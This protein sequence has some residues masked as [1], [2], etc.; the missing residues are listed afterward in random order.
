MGD[1]RNKIKNHLNC[2]T[3]TKLIISSTFGDWTDLYYLYV[4]ETTIK[5]KI[6]FK[7]WLT[8]FFEF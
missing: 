5:K 1:V 3:D 2:I 6:S 4:N 8:I 7:H